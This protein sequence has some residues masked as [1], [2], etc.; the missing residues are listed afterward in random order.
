MSCLE[1]SEQLEDEVPVLLRIFLV[2]YDDSDYETGSMRMQK[3]SFGY[4]IGQVLVLGQSW[5]G[6]SI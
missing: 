4:K 1:D 3:T 2:S 6:F 5:E